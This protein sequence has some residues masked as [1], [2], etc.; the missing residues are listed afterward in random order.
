MMTLIGRTSNVL[1]AFGLM[2][3]AMVFLT[4]YTALAPIVKAEMFPTKVRAL[5]VGLPH[6]L[7]TAI[8]GGTAEPIALALKQAGHEPLFFWY[9][10]GCV[11]L[12]G[13]AVALVKEPSRNSTLDRLPTADTVVAG[14]HESP[15]R[16]AAAHH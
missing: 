1:V 10:T 12:T 2:A 3:V 11:A 6:A 7:V 8:F 14:T 4:G 16:P 13:I 5:G 9:V 15:L